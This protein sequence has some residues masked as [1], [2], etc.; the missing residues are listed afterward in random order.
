MK[1]ILLLIV[2]LSISCSNTSKKGM[3]FDT[4]IISLDS[5]KRNIETKKD[6]LDTNPTYSLTNGSTLLSVSGDFDGDGIKETLYEHYFS[7]K[8]KKEVQVPHTKDD[9]SD[10]EDGSFFDKVRDLG[11]RSFMTCSN[12]KIDTLHLETPECSIYSYK[13]GKW[14]E[15]YSFPTWTWAVEE[16]ADK[17]GLIRK[18]SNNKIEVKYRTD[19]AYQD[20]M[21]IDLN[22]IKVSKDDSMIY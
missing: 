7:N 22:N 4:K 12:N 9:G 21:I 11:P 3:S 10:F 15:L 5:I 20:T 19:E 14:I 18:I 17:G 1:Y 8:L 6:T 2:I 16:E 13:S